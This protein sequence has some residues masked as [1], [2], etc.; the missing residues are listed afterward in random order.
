MRG[1]HNILWFYVKKAA[2]GMGGGEPAE[3]K[4]GEIKNRRF[5]F[6]IPIDREGINRVY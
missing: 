6:E 3:A 1:E 4:E 5:S 2:A